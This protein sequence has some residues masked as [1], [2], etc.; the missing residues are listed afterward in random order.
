MAREESDRE[1]LLREAV[2]LIERVELKPPAGEN[3]FFGFRRDG[4]A[5]CY[6]GPDPAFHFNTRHELRRAYVDGLLY[7][8]EQRKLIALRRERTTGEVQLIRHEC[9][10][11]ETAALLD[12]LET[13]LSALAAMLASGE[14]TIVGQVPSEIDVVAR[15]SDWLQS[16]DR[17][18][19]IATSPHA[20]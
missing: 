20:R 8:A 16:L 14:L 6:F 3:I 5:S 13:R 17:P 11:K 12:D 10:R 2:A 9:D 4:S 19:A 1:D 18:I 7:K 15:V